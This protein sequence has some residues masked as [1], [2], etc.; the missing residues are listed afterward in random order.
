MTRWYYPDN[1]AKIEKSLRENENN[2]DLDTD[3]G[4]YKVMLRTGDKNLSKISNHNDVNPKKK[5]IYTTIYYQKNIILIQKP[6]T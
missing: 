1:L 3:Y 5:N 6:L 2:I 4:S